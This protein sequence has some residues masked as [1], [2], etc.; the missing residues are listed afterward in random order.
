MNQVI[1]DL[2]LVG[3]K[4]PIPNGYTAFTNTA[5][6]KEPALRKQVLCA[7]YTLKNFTNAA[8]VDI[9]LFKDNSYREK[10]YTLVG[11]VF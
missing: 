3:I 9:G 1:T 10:M 8:I 6:T 7:R 11:Y 4:D 2:A 5:D